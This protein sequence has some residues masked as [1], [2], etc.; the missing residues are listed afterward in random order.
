[1][2][3][4]QDTYRLSRFALLRAGKDGFLLESPLNDRQFPVRGVS[5][6]RILEA[7]SRPV[8]LDALLAR[9]EEPEREVL[10]SFLA[11]CVEAK[12]L[13]RVGEDG[14]TEEETGPL[15]YWEF[16]DLLFHASTRFGRNLRPIG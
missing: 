14:L 1:M 8:R 6:L 7:L 10:Q 16:H 5:V 11:T 15:G 4:W 12:L 13:T 9:V 3:N 2:L